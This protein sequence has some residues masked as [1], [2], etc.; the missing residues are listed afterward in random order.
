[1]CIRDSYDST[2]VDWGVSGAGET[3][4]C[5]VTVDDGF[6]EATATVA[7]ELDAR[8]HNVLV[9]LA[10][11]LGTDKVAAYGEHPEPP[12]TP[13]ID[14]LAAD[15]VLFRNAWANPVCSP[16]RATLLTGR[17]ARR[18]GVGGVVEPED[19]TYM[20]PYEEE[21]IPELL[22]ESHVPY[23]TMWIGKWHLASFESEDSFD[24]PVLSGFARFT[25]ALGNLEVKPDGLGSYDYNQWWKTE[26]LS[27]IHI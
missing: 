6:D 4:S 25:G 22:S 1:M 26:G 14:Q 11:D 27:L 15:G 3:W 12:P 8:N 17:H 2:Q 20:L 24:H 7:V 9:L 16:T 23:D 18:H 10:D 19:N 5:R 13:H 21:L